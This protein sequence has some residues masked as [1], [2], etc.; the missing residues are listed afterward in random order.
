MTA[1]QNRPCCYLLF[2]PDRVK[3]V[4][5]TVGKEIFVLSLNVNAANTQC[6][7]AADYRVLCR[8]SLCV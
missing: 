3:T 7:M 5:P 8:R 1:G 6:Y 4:I 2:V